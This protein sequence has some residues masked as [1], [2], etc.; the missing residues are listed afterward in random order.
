[1]FMFVSLVIFFNVRIIFN[2]NYENPGS[3]IEHS[4]NI[5]LFFHLKIPPPRVFRLLAPSF[6]PQR[7]VFIAAVRRRAVWGAGVRSRLGLELE[8]GLDGG[9]GGQRQSAPAGVQQQKLRR[10]EIRRRRAPRRGLSSA[11][12]DAFVRYWKLG[13]GFCGVSVCGFPR[14]LQGCSTTVCVLQMASS[15]S[16]VFSSLSL[17]KRIP[18]DVSSGCV[19]CV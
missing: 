15:D 6:P 2:K 3:N 8:R 9:D 18:G 1:M 13:R 14:L 10:V 16:K 12:T 17:R 5:P 19:F 4:G 11:F 7:V